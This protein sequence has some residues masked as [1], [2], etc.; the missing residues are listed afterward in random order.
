[1]NNRPTGARGDSTTLLQHHRYPAHAQPRPQAAADSSPQRP[2]RLPAA[3]Y[4][5]IAALLLAGVVGALALTGCSRETPPH[6]V[7]E[8]PDAKP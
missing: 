3:R 4:V 5:I 6:A 1:M 2:A 7:G 8:R